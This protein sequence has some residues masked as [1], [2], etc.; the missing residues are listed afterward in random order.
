MALSLR[1]DNYGVLISSGGYGGRLLG[2]AAE[3]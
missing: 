1:R 3:V 2:I